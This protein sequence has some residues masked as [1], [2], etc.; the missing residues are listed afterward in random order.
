MIGHELAI[1]Q[2]EMAE[3]KPGYEPRQRNLRRVGATAEHR[4]AEEGPAKAHAV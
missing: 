3:A 2:Q 4:F 1:E